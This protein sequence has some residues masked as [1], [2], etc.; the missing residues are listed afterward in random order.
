MFKRDVDFCSGAFFLTP[1]SLF[2]ELDGLDERYVP[3]YYEETDY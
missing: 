1:R 2:K 3:A